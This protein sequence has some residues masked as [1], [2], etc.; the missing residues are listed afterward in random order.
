MGKI[1]FLIDMD[2]ILFIGDNV[3][4]GGKEFITYLK[5]HNLPFMFLTNGSKCTPLDYTLRLKHLGLDVSEDHFYTAAMAT[6]HYVKGQ[7]AD[8]TAYVLGEAGLLQA[9]HAEG[10]ASNDKNPDFVILGD[11][12]TFNCEVLEKAINFV[13]A[14]AKLVVT[15]KDPSP[16][17]QKWPKPA[18]KALTAMLEEATNREAFVTGKPSPIMMRY[19]RKALDLRTEET[20]MIG[21]IM[22]TDILGGVFLGYYTILALTGMTKREDLI[23]YAY[24]PNKIVDNISD[25]MKLLEEG[26]IFEERLSAQI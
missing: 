6:A 17:E 14:G 25:V 19:A 11:T 1:G 13:L 16:F 8:G 10:I 12:R 15:N 7:K 24:Q 26:K 18:N 2:G 9:L 23:K 22:E 3:L 5:K 4:P 20:V 21:D